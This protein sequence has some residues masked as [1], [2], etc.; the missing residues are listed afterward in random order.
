MYVDF[1][2]LYDLV[3]TVDILLVFLTLIFSIYNLAH[4]LFM[5]Y[6]IVA[7][8]KLQNR[9]M[10]MAFERLKVIIIV[11]LCRYIVLFKF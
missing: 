1:S 7:F 10:V 8:R 6:I 5:F 4:V 2:A 9:R 3:T 11:L